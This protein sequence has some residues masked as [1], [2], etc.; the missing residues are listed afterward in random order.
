MQGQSFEPFPHTTTTTTTTQA[1]R[2]H[3]LSVSVK[4]SEVPGPRGKSTE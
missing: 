2:G 1:W 3:S 4:A